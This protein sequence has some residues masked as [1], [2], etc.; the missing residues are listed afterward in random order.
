MYIIVLKVFFLSSLTE[1]SLKAGY[2]LGKGNLF[3]FPPVDGK[4]IV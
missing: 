1:L 4:E 2:T 3:P